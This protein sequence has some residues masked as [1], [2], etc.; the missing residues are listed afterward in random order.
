[1]KN[2]YYLDLY[3]R[4]TG[5]PAPNFDDYMDF[6][7]ILME[8]PLEIQFDARGDDFGFRFSA[9]FESPEL[10]EAYRTLILSEAKL[11]FDHFVEVIETPWP[12]EIQKHNSSVVHY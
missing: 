5:F 9:N 3:F 12:Q 11:E 10:R 2:N 1:M 4:N 6:I 7:C 8:E